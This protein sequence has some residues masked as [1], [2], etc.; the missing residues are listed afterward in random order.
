MGELRGEPHLAFE[1]LQV[2]LGFTELTLMD[3]QKLEWIRAND[4]KITTSLDG[5]EDV[6]DRNRRYDTGQATYKDVAEKLKMCREK[7]MRVGAL[8]VTTRY[9]LDKHKEIIDEYV[10]Q[11]LEGIQL[12]YINKIGFAEKTWKEKAL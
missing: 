11:G 10:K 9:S 6:H 12:K 3:E 5:P 2:V 1:P 7:R 8:M 4:V